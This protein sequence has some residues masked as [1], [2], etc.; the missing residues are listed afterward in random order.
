MGSW[1]DFTLWSWDFILFYFILFYF[2]L[3][4]FISTNASSLLRREDVHVAPKSPI[5]PL[6]RHLTFS[7]SDS[8]TSAWFP[9]LD[10]NRPRRPD[11]L[12]HENR[13]DCLLHEKNLGLPPVAS[14]FASSLLPTPPPGATTTALGTSGALRPPSSSFSLL[15]LLLPP[16]LSLKR[17]RRGARR[18]RSLQV[19]VV[20]TAPVASGAPWLP[21][22]S[23]LPLSL[24]PS[25]RGGGAASSSGAACRQRLCGGAGAGAAALVGSEGPLF[26]P[27]PSCGR[28]E[29]LLPPRHM[30]SFYQWNPRYDGGWAKL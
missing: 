23:S 13:P 12:L 17:R 27:H 29:C 4:Y 6:L 30:S 16:S 2:I 7:S 1:I 9:P 19:R 20:A 21:S 3:F 22:S 11:S 8:S 15:L 28:L 14:L 18:R 26:L 24:P 25:S 10:T 5:G